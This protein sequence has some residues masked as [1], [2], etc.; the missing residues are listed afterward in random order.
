ML[1]CITDRTETCPVILPLLAALAIIIAASKLGGWLSGV[2]RQPVVLGELL[3]GLLLG[4]SVLGLF[5]LP[6]FEAA[7]VQGA[8]E[9]FGE[10]GV[11]FLMFTAGLEVQIDD[12]RKSGQ[13]SIW[14]GVLGV[15]AGVL[16]VFA[17]LVLGGAAL[18]PFGYAFDQAVFLGL[19]MAA[20]SVS[21]SAQTLIEMNRLRSVEGLTLL[22]AAVVDDVLAIA[23]LSAFTALALG[24]EGGLG[25]L[26]WTLLRM[27]LFLVGS[28]V[29][30]S[31]L[32]P[33]AVDWVEE[34]QWAISEPVLSLVVVMVLAFAWASEFVGG[35]AAI[36]GAFIAGVA[37]ARSSLKGKIERGMH[38]LAYAFFVPIFLVGIGLQAD[39]R[40]LSAQDLGLTVR[41][42]PDGL[43]GRPGGRHE[44]ARRRGGGAPRRFEATFGVAGGDRH[45]LARRSRPDRG[46]GRCHHGP[47]R[48]LGV[49]GRGHDGAG[50]HDRHTAL[51][52]LGFPRAGCSPKGGH[53]CLS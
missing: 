50:H 17:P 27:A 28:F 20:T 19:V 23:A 53:T 44:A 51:A 25:G 5:S 42:R 33:R 32:L 52:A 49:H 24:G 48:W 11:I 30:G 38:V 46:L 3:I 40:A 1:Q 8:L 6:Y 4:P 39:A 9:E 15:F 14:A 41:P 16:G 13:P 34:R 29:L 47:A 31:R 21:I 45:D 7:H 36:T 10:L 26:V 2:L 43:G 22:G 12:L 37:L 18:L 35:V